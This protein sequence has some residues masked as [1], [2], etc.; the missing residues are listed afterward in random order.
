MLSPSQSSQWTRYPD[1]PIILD[2]QDEHR[3]ATF[4]ARPQRTSYVP[5]AIPRSQSIRYIT[6]TSPIQTRS[7][8]QDRTASEI[9]RRQSRRPMVRYLSPIRSRYNQKSPNQDPIKLGQTTDGTWTTKYKEK[10]NLPWNTNPRFSGDSFS[11]NTRQADPINKPALGLGIMNESYSPASILTTSSLA[12]RIEDRLWRCNSSGNVAERWSLEIFSW[13]ISA[14]CMSAVIIILLYI[15][16]KGLP[17]WPTSLALTV[18]FKIS[19]A[20]LLLPTSEA[21]GQLKWSWIQRDSKMW[22]FEM[23]DL[24]SR[25]PWG[26]LLLLLRTKCT[27]VSF[28]T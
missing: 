2:A 17:N 3:T 13:I 4:F 16:G 1:I 23:F 18:F 8:F 15:K 9:I 11:Q 19:S 27:Y 5:R 14:M 26:S 12:Q 25:G 28:V 21:L 10:R 6:V 24:A 7:R 22:D 20:A